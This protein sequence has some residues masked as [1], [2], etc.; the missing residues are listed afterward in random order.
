[1]YAI[2]KLFSLSFIWINGQNIKTPLTNYNQSYKSQWRIAFQHA[3]EPKTIQCFKKNY[4]MAQYD[5]CFYN[6]LSNQ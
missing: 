1:M 3:K 6:P 4:H 5:S 2:S